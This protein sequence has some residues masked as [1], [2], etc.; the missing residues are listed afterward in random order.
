MPEVGRSAGLTLVPE[1]PLRCL[2]EPVF[3]TPD[4]ESPCLRAGPCKAELGEWDA[5]LRSPAEGVDAR[6]CLPHCVPAGIGIG[7]PKSQRVVLDPR[8]V[9]AQ[10]GPTGVVVISVQHEHQIVAARLV[11]SP[12]EAGPDTSR[13]AAVEHPR[14]DVKRIV[15]IEKANQSALRGGLAFI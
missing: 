11:I 13:S 8:R 12:R 9:D 5:N 7:P 3:V 10:H 1:S 4:L 15:V 14:S 2:L 6:Y